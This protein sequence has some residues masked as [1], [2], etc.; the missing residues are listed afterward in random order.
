MI[1]NNQEFLSH[2]SRVTYAS[3]INWNP[4]MLMP[5]HELSLLLFF[6]SNVFFSSCVKRR[7]WAYHFY[8]TGRYNWRLIEHAQR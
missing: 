4:S 6:V 5:V 7:W 8:S 1:H 2:E 3:S